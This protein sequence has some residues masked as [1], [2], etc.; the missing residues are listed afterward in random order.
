MHFE[1]RQVFLIAAP[2]DVHLRL[3]AARSGS[4]PDED[5]L[6]HAA[7]FILLGA[8]A[9]LGYDPKRIETFETIHYWAYVVVFGLFMV[10]LI[11]RMLLHTFKKR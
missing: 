3:Q 7:L 6:C 1:C 2:G 8:L 5:G 11:F 9:G 4:I 10:D